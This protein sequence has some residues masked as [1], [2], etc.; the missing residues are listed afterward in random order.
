M[1]PVLELES[2][3]RD[4]VNAPRRQARIFNDKVAWE[5]SAALS[6]SSA[7]QRLPR[8]LPEHKRPCRTA[9][10]GGGPSPRNWQP[11]YYVIWHSSNSLCSTGCREALGRA[12]GLD[13]DH[14]PTLKDVRRDQERRDWTPDQTRQR[15]SIQF[16]LRPT[17][18][19]D[20]LHVTHDASRWKV[21]RQRN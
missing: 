18:L 20:W 11:L 9:E 15:R 6:M 10:E 5:C 8:G 2:Q 12:L 3:I 14:E 13:Y 21:Q 7:T 16:Y 19:A 1:T 17:L 4:F